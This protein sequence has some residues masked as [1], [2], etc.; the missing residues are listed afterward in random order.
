MNIILYASVVFN[1]LILIAFHYKKKC[2]YNENILTDMVLS[3][4]LSSLFKINLLAIFLDCKLDKISLT[5]EIK[6][7]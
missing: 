2:K 6:I 1:I 5:N 4:E 7:N 3:V